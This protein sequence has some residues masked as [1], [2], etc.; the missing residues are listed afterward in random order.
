MTFAG[1]PLPSS[2]PAFLALLAVHVAAGIT[3]VLAGAVAMLSRKAPGRHPRFGSIYYWSLAIVF[4]TAVVLSLVRWAE[5]WHL[6]VLAVLAFGLAALG[7]R[8]IRRQPVP[9]VR[10]HMAGM[11]LSYIVLLTAFYV[12]NGKNL[13]VWRELPSIAYWTLPAVIGLPI[14]VWAL[15]RHPKVRDPGRVAPVGRP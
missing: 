1:I 12:D 14:L 9:A 2:A 10:L 3:C 11:G 8:S 4:P 5:D 15:L 6:F 13:P 7:R